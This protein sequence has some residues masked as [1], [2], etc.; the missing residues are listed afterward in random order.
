MIC[1]GALIAADPVSSCPMRCPDCE[2]ENDPGFRFCE[3][4]GSRLERL[5]VG[6]GGAVSAAARFCGQCG[7]ALDGDAA[8]ARG[9]APARSLPTAEVRTSERRQLTVMFCDI[10]GST[11]LAERLDPEELRDVL[12][13]Y[14][15]VCADAV[16][17]FDGHVAQYLGDG[18]LVYFGYPQAHEDDPERAMRAGLAIQHTLESSE[19]ASVRAR[20]GIHT[21][22]VIV[23][24]IGTAERRET[25][26]TGGTTNLAARIEGQAAPGTVVISEATNRLAAGLFVTRDLGPV[27]IHGISETVRLFEVKRAVAARSRLESNASLTPL[28]GRE[29]ELGL[30]LDGWE[31]ARDGA[32]QLLVVPGEAGIGKSRLVQAFRERLRDWPHGWLGMQCSAY[33]T[34]AAFQPV[35]DLLESSL[36]IENH[37]TPAERAHALEEGL[38]TSTI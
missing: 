28:V 25:L 18:V 9:D 15:G 32:G 20:I 38:A 17:R 21:G 1:E 31:R 26:A 29:R 33:A 37:A 23:G 36:G 14:H 27:E 12:N 35:V 4:C 13:D 34:G 5:C 11:E 3:T 16:K 2:H 10:V 22:L 30:L 24:E 8:E 7:L 6:C 19:H